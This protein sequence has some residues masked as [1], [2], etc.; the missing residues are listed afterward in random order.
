MTNWKMYGE[1][2]RQ[3]KLG[4]NKSQASRKLKLD[5]KTIRKYWDIPPDEFSLTLEETRSRCKKADIYEKELV[6]WLR[7]YPDISTA[8]LHDWLKEKYKKIDLSDRTLRLYVAHLREEYGIPK[9]EAARQYEALE[10]PPMGFQAQV[11]MGEIWLERTKGK[12]VKVY[13]FA[14]VLSHSRYK[15]VFWSDKPFTTLQFIDAHN[16]A[17]EFFG[18]RPEELAYD[19]D[20]VLAV[21]ENHGDIIYTEGFQRY[22]DMMKFKIYL[23]RPADPAT[24]GR[25]EAV[26]KYVKYNFAKHRIFDNITDFNSLCLSWLERT[27][28]AKVHETTKKV[29]AEVFALEKQHLIPVP[30]N[31]IKFTNDS[32]TYHVRKD[33]TIIYRQNRYRVPVGTYK[34][35]KTVQIL[36][37]EDRMKLFDGDTGEIYAYHKVSCDKGR[38]IPLNHADRDLNNTL[39]TLYQKAFELLLYTDNARLLLDGIRTAKPRYFRDQLGVIIKVCEGNPEKS[40]LRQAIDYCVLKNLWSAGDFKSSIQYFEEIQKQR[41]RPSPIDKPK[42]PEKYKGMKPKV[43]DINEYTKAMEGCAVNE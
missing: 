23:C 16:K 35:G 25:I 11:D 13:C 20:K 7:E 21:S 37:D 22:I 33:N 28:N 24:K 27:G 32:L 31:E 26:V 19:Q 36:L 38:L 8:Q 3:K 39:E 5:I 15:Y 12:R 34:P 41:P 14:M 18:G 30:Y 4:L 1:I 9:T 40:I 10:D 6:E 29:P 43:R 42:L 17:F 2:Q